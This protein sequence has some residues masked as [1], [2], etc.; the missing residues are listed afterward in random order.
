MVMTSH[1]RSRTS[2][3]RACALSTVSQVLLKGRGLQACLNHELSTRD[4]GQDDAHLATR[5][6]YGYLRYKGRLDFLL[7]A[8]CTSGLNRLPPGFRLCLGL[9]CYEILFLDRVPAYATVNWVVNQV[10]KAFSRKLAGLA[11]GVLRNVARRADSL[12]SY[13][14]ITADRPEERIALSRWYSCPVWIVDLLLESMGES[15][16]VSLLAS[17]LDPPPV[18]VRFHPLRGS[19]LRDELTS[20]PD[21]LRSCHTGMAFARTPDAR[22]AAWER[23]GRLSRQSLAVQNMLMDLGALDWPSPVWDACAGNGGKSGLLREYAASEVWSS[24]RVLAKVAQCRNEMHRLRLD[25]ALAFVADA[26]QPGPFRRPPATVLLDVP[27][28]G[29]GVLSRRPDIKWKRKPQDVS[30]MVGL[31]KTMLL[32]ACDTLRPGSRLIYVT[33]TVNSQENEHQIQGLLR[34]RPGQ[35]ELKRMVPHDPVVP[36]GEA[37]FGAMLEKV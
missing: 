34:E 35:V 20:H 22:L 16:C 3:A 24:D 14:F 8:L 29:L 23:E 2:S 37:L 30:A 36:L 9:G 7:D 15:S 27:C 10:K 25:P 33:C 6:S 32:S 28:S 5:I 13:A 26:T 17:S 12:N 19:G 11:N 18:G 1:P 31:Q 4:L 21:L